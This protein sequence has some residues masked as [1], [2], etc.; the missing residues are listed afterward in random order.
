[1]GINITG[2]TITNNEIIIDYKGGG[3][4][5]KSMI[6]NGIDLEGG[7]A[8]FT[9]YSLINSTGTWGMNNKIPSTLYGTAVPTY[10]YTLDSSN[11]VISGLSRGNCKGGIVGKQNVFPSYKGEKLCYELINQISH[12]KINTIIVETCAGNCGEAE[13]AT[14]CASNMYK[15]GYRAFP[16]QSCTPMT[17]NSNIKWDTLPPISGSGPPSTLKYITPG[18]KGCL[19]ADWCSGYYAHFDLDDRIPSTFFGQGPDGYILNEGVMKYTRITC[20]SPL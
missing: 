9:T 10:W 1:M 6:C 20:P 5:K 8:S 18:P 14:C 16:S 12:E 15:S 11:K 7:Y 2:L 19:R 3:E 13:C 17:N 4:P